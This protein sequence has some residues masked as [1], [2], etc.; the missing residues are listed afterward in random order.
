MQ[1]HKNI[2]NYGKNFNIAPSES[3]KMRE[4]KLIKYI[5]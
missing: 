4:Q 3:D 5:I 1:E 2:I